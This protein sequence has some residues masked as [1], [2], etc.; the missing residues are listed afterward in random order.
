MCTDTDKV[1]GDNSLGENEQFIVNY[2]NNT[3]HLDD[4]KI[5]IL[6][7]LS[8]RIDVNKPIFSD[9]RSFDQVMSKH[10]YYLLLKDGEAE[11]KETKVTEDTQAKAVES[12]SVPVEQTVEEKETVE[13]P[14]FEERVEQYLETLDVPKKD[15]AEIFCNYIK[16]NEPSEPIEPFKVVWN[17]FLCL[18]R[19]PLILVYVAANTDKYNCNQMEGIWNCDKW[20]VLYKSYQDSNKLVTHSINFA[21]FEKQCNVD[22]HNFK[23]T[24]ETTEFLWTLFKSVPEK[25]EFMNGL[26]NKI[27]V[28]LSN[29]IYC[30]YYC[31]GTHTLFSIGKTRFS[32]S[33]IKIRQISVEQERQFSKN[34]EGY[35]DGEQYYVYD[36]Y[37]AQNRQIF[38]WS[39]T[40]LKDNIT[41]Y[42]S[43]PKVSDKD[44]AEYVWS[45]K[46]Y[47]EG[48]K[49]DDI[50]GYHAGDVVW[51]AGVVGHIWKFQAKINKIRGLPF[52]GIYISSK[53]QH[54]KLKTFEVSGSSIKETYDAGKLANI[55]EHLEK[56]E[57]QNCVV[58]LQEVMGELKNHDPIVVFQ[59][60]KHLWTASSETGYKM[61]DFV[62]R[63]MVNGAF[64]ETLIPI[65]SYD[66]EGKL[67]SPPQETKQVEKKLET[68]N[69]F[70]AINYLQ[71]LREKKL[72]PKSIMY[73]TKYGVWFISQYDNGVIQLFDK[74]IPNKEDPTVVL[75]DVRQFG[76][77]GE[78]F[79]Y[80]GDDFR[81]CRVILTYTHTHSDPFDTKLTSD[82]SHFLKSLSNEQIVTL[83]KNGTGSYMWYTDTHRWYRHNSSQIF[84]LEQTPLETKSGKEFLVVDVN[85]FQTNRDMTVCWIP[86]DQAFFEIIYKNPE[87]K[88]TPISMAGYGVRIHGDKLNVGD[89]YGLKIARTTCGCYIYYFIAPILESQ[90]GVICTDIEDCGEQKAVLKKIVG[91]KRNVPPFGLYQ[92]V[93]GSE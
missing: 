45:V 90:G 82:D 8:K 39:E 29:S 7:Q 91:N 93:S 5:M 75:G 22:V 18:V 58:K 6:Y 73:D 81:H 3:P 41:Q 43:D 9:G 92:L 11:N 87:A 25:G 71:Q 40:Q 72:V 89:L 2:I 32:C 61:Y 64:D 77:E 53:K 48:W 46:K 86:K 54:L 62:P 51:Y 35:S 1:K 12:P 88:F 70:E 47:Y 49:V 24:E 38:C 68:M 14:T 16:A 60:D 28:R 59:T 83:L 4:V 63:Y 42:L 30:Y 66:T 37:D 27:Q 13:E 55:I 78:P 76:Y 15:F 57:P 74:K 85:N 69:I 21:I 17:G 36:E 65:C 44:K 84:C 31:P 26:F 52:K 67:I 20:Y 19:L 10:L 80:Q 56:L 23:T 50:N 34:S 33:A 79:W